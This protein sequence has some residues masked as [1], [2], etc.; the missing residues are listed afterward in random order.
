V[1]RTAHHSSDPPNTPATVTA[2]T[3]HPPPETASPAPA[4]MPAKARIVCGF[5][6]VRPRA[7]PYAP[8]AQAEEAGA[9]QVGGPAARLQS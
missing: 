7:E 4:K 5:A 9:A 8:Q 1:T 6:S 3:A 2:G